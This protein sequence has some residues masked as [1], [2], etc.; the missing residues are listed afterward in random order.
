VKSETAFA[1][2]AWVL[3][4][5]IS[6]PALPARPAV[7]ALPGPPALQTRPP[8]ARLFPPLDLG[9]LEGP[10]REQ[11]QKPDLIMDALGI[12][13]GSQVAEIGAAGGWFTV[14]LAR[15][16]GPNGRVYAE[17][18]QPQMVD[19]IASRVQR[20]NLQNVV[21][22][23]GRPDNPRLPAPIDA[24]LMVETFHELEDPVALLKNVAR[25]LKPQGRV[26]NVDFNPGAG[27]PGP[28]P[29]E[30]VD[31]QS[32]IQAAAAAGLRLTKREEVPPFQFLLVFEKDEGR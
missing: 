32:V 3:A 27:G 9:L 2:L 7:P 16:V 20:D 30:R 17:D 23:L 8:K 10:D 11:W 18:I 21:T 5:S 24:A 28:A 15:R 26:G 12:A 31:P 13:E 19:A 29:N 14:R 22:I 25:S 6:L 1:A 4:S